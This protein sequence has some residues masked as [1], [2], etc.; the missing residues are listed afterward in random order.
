MGTTT[1][2]WNINNTAENGSYTEMFSCITKFNTL[3]F[4]TVIIAVVGL[5]GNGIVLWLL[6]FH[7]HRNAFSVYVLNLSCADFL[8]ICTQFVHSLQ[9]FL[10]ILMIYYHFILTGF[11]IA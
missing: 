8:Q 7:L 6:A 4:L 2:A 10:K 5:A 11:M 9:C 3:N 1:L